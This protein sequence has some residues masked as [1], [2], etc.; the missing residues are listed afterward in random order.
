MKRALATDSIATATRVVGVKEGD[1]E[2]GKGD[3]DGNS[4]EEANGDRWRPM[5]TTRVMATAKRLTGK[6]WWQQWQWGWGWREGHGHSHYN[7]REGDDGGD[8]PRFVCE[9][10]CVW[11]DHEK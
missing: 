11:R 2:G 8:E 3:S 6:Q 4:N 10:L 5:A 1:D 9:F 7:W